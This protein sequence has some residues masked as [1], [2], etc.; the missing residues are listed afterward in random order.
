MGVDSSTIDGM[1]KKVYTSKSIE[2]LQ[3]ME[4]GTY[5]KLK[6]SDKKPDGQGY[7]FGVNVKG[8]ERGQGYQNELEALRTAGSQTPVQGVVLPKIAT[9]TIRF[10]GL[11]LEIAEG[12]EESM[13]DNVTFQ[14]DEG[15]KDFA[16]MRNAAFFRDGTGK[17]AQVN[18]AV[19]SSTSVVVNNGVLTHLRVGMF[20]DAIN[21]GGTKQISGIE[22]LDVD[23]ATSTIT[24]ASAQSCDDDCWIYREGTADNAPTDGK[25]IAGLK[26]ITDDG[27][28]LTIFEGINRTTYP[29]FQGLQLAAAGANVSDDILQRADS[30]VLIQGNRKTTDV[31]SSTSQF[32]KYLSIVTPMKEYKDYNAKMDTGYIPMPTW[33]GKTWHVDTDCQDDTVWLVNMQYLERYVTKDIHLDDKTGSRFRWDSGYDAFVTVVKNYENAGTRVPNTHIGVTGLAVATY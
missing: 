18:G 26:L 21:S 8:N 2:N 20:I 14:V 23:I 19:S 27:T 17:L 16:K 33:N 29:K 5:K 30:R 6:I 3:N 9:H 11:S 22:I 12:G 28:V 32:R 10:S 13:A 4:D 7:T 1:L 31:I 24:L 15:I 25:E